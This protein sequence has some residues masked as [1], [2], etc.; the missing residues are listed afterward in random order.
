MKWI[1]ASEKIIETFEKIIPSL[2]GVK[3]RKMFGCFNPEFFVVVL[4]N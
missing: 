4:A 1:E 3:K 2:P